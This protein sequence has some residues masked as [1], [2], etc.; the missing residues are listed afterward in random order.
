MIKQVRI[1]HCFQCPHIC[2]ATWNTQTLGYCGLKDGKI[3][4]YIDLGSGDNYGFPEWCPLED[5]QEK[6]NKEREKANDLHN[7]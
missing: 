7:L 6:D 5:Y 1:F 3:I 4:D 2:A